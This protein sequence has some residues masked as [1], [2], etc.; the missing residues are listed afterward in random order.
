ML[1]LD[2]MLCMHDLDKI[3]NDPPLFCYYTSL[4]VGEKNYKFNE[5]SNIKPTAF[6]VKITRKQV[7]P[8]SQKNFKVIMH[9]L[10][11]LPQC[12]AAPILQLL[13]RMNLERKI[14]FAIPFL[15]HPVLSVFVR[16]G[17]A[18]ANNTKGYC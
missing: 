7:M 10:L 8:R 14:T 1:N 12:T 16:R 3:H 2:N 6:Y 5:M 4:N 11:G 13:R 17:P 18:T 15:T 9:G